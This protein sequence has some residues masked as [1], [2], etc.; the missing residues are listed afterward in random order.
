MH[1]FFGMTGQYITDEWKLQSVMLSC[2]QLT[3][4]HTGEKILCTFEEITTDFHIS[5]KVDTLSQT[6]QVI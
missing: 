6:M 3:G 1:S 5:T 4:S 2:D